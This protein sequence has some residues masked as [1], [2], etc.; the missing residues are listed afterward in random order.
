MG[1]SWEFQTFQEYFVPETGTS[2][3]GLHGNVDFAVGGFP[4]RPSSKIPLDA[5]KVRYTVIEYEVSRH[6]NP[7]DLR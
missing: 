1:P 7:P 6:E 2:R 4:F 5:V 3:V